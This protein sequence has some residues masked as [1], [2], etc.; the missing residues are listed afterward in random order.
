MQRQ[1][2]LPWLTSGGGGVGVGRVAGASFAV[3][4]QPRAS[5]FSLRISN[6]QGQF[7]IAVSPPPRLLRKV[8]G[9]LSYN[10]PLPCKH[11]H[12]PCTLT[13]RNPSAL[14]SPLHIGSKGMEK[15]D[16]C[17]FNFLF[18]FVSIVFCLSVQ[19]G[20]DAQCGICHILPLGARR[21]T[22]SSVADGKEI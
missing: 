13:H 2:K 4:E 5:S 14:N 21:I 16:R 1:D 8:P 12:P 17:N 15:R 19:E 6:P 3:N 22:A 9:I 10:P 20:R 7:C 11:R 18:C